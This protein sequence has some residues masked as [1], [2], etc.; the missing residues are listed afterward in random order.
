VVLTKVV[1]EIHPLPDAFLVARTYT[2]SIRSQECEVCPSL[3]RLR[4]EERYE[5]ARSSSL[6]SSCQ[7]RTLLIR[8]PH[9]LSCRLTFYY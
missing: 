8:L 3:L 7:A 9:E 5:L 6:C 4:D 2:C 1:D